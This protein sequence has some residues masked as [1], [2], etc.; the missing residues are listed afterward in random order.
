MRTVRTK[1]R[2]VRTMWEQKWEQSQTVICL[3][4]WRP[5]CIIKNENT[6][7]NFVLPKSNMG[8]QKTNKI[9]EPI[10]KEWG[11]EHGVLFSLAPSIARRGGPCSHYR[12]WEQWEQ[13]AENKC[14][15]FRLV[16]NSVINE[17]DCGQLGL[18]R[19]IRT[20]GVIANN[21]E[22]VGLLRTSRIIANNCEQDV[23]HWHTCEVC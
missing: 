12:K 23:L 2:T 4:I 22:Q 7:N 15:Q 19:T 10:E 21:C 11:W 16:E 5:G 20:I 17:G 9:C 6:E 18:L 14:S 13:T 3:A 1:V 8:N